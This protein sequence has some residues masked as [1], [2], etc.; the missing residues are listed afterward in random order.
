M[1]KEKPTAVILQTKDGTV[2]KD[3]MIRSFV[4]FGTPRW[5]CKFWKSEGWARRSARKLGL[6]EW[7]IVF[8]YDGDSIDATGVVTRV[9]THTQHTQ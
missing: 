7:K 9:S 5:A 3:G 1:K 6:R 4:N 8:L 2:C